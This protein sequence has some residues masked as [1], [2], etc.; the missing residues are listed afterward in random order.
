[1]S[2]KQFC[3]LHMA[4]L[5]NWRMIHTVQDTFCNSQKNAIYDHLSTNSLDISVR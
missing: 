1:M 3:N 5:S 4:E 2:Y